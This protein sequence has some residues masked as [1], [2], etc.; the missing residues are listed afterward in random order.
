MISEDITKVFVVVL[1]IIVRV[2]VVITCFHKSSANVIM[3]FVK[4]S[5]N[6][7]IHIIRCYALLFR[8]LLKIYLHFH[9]NLIF[10]CEILYQTSD[11]QDKIEYE[12]RVRKASSTIFSAYV[13]G[14][15]LVVL[16]IYKLSL[17]HSLF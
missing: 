10:M 17:M 11:G 16:F 15:H 13:K 7:F 3:I 6:L 1:F 14:R 2:Q 12:I 9:L 5:V 4:K 8:P